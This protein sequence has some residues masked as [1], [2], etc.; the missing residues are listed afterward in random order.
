MREETYS[1]SIVGRQVSV[2]LVGATY[3]Y[4]RSWLVS[5]PEARL[6][7]DR[8]AEVSWGPLD[9]YY[10]DTCGFAECLHVEAVREHELGPALPL[11]GQLPLL[12]AEEAR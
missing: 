9:G 11:P 7:A 2:K 8:L 10:C 12:A 1:S 3:P 6:R 5:M 4:D